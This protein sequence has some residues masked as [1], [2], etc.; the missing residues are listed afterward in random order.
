MKKEIWDSGDRR[1]KARKEIPRKMMKGISWKT[2]VQE[3]RRTTNNL[4]SRKMELPKG[5]RKI[6]ET[7]QF[8]GVLT[9]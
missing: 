3:A 5:K 4:D 8:S 1:F 7:D 9:Y 6:L 2:A